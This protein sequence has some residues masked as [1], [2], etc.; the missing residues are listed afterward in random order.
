[1]SEKEATDKLSR[2]EFLSWAVMGGALAAAYGLITLYVGRFLYPVKKKAR[3]RAIFVTTKS[4]L[5]PGKPLAWTAPNGQKVLIH[6]VEKELLALSNVCPHL[7]CKVNWEQVN[8]RFFC[9]CHAGVFDKNGIA[10]AGPPA[11]EGKNLKRYELTVKGDA[12]Y[13]R[14]EET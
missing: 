13:L 11:A 14:W 9:P 10:I 5:K 7:G 8:D 6:Q 3:V 4:A 12:V 1:M 2:R